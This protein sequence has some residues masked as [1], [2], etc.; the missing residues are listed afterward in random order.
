MVITADS[1][2]W[3]VSKESYLPGGV[4][5]ILR[6]KYRALIDEKSITK[7]RLGNWVA[8]TL[9]HNRKA[10]L[11]INVYRLPYTTQ[12]GPRSCLTQYNVL[13]GNAKPASEIRKDTLKQIKQYIYQNTEIDDIIIAGDLNENVNSKEIKKFF[14]DIGVEDIHSRYNNIPPKEMDKTFINGSNPIDTI[15]ASEGIMK[16]IEGSKL[17]SHTEIVPTDYRAYVADINLED[18]FNDECSPWENINHVTL[19]PA[20]KSYR[21]KF[22]EEVEEQLDR[23]QIENLIENCPYPTYQQIE[24]FDEMI[25]SILNK[26]TKKVEGQK[27]GIPYSKVKVKGRD[28][29]KFW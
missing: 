20:R 6:G 9:K 3:S 7:G 14:N 26:A 1:T 24:Y 11:V 18:Y 13:E 28:E 2:M 19:D 8:V 23:T 15:A 12:Q 5:T 17:I 4:A 27:R 22:F 25:T 21:T 16:N 10:I 29:I